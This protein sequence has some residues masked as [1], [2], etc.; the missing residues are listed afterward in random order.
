MDLHTRSITGIVVYAIMLPA[1]FGPFDFYSL[2]PELSLLFSS[3]MLFISAIRL[4]FWLNTDRIYKASGRL[5]RY[6]FYFLSTCHASVLATFFFY[7]IFD[8]SFYPVLY[9]SMLAIGGITSS[10]LIALSPRIKFAVMNV[11]VL[12]LPSIIGGLLIDDKLPFAIMMFVYTVFI[13]LLGIRSHKEYVRSFDIETQL[14]EQKQALEHINKTDA[15]TNVYNRGFFNIE[16]ESQWQSAARHN[17][18]M[19]LMFIDIDHFKKFND[20]H[21]HLVGD[22]C[23][24]Q[25]AQ[26][27]KT[28]ITRETD[29][30]A[31]YGGEEFVVLLSGCNLNDAE[32]LAEGLCRLID[33]ATIN[34][35]DKSL[36]VTASIGVASITPHYKIDS[37]QLIDNAD[38]ALY[39][40]KNAGRNCV[41]A[42]K[43][44]LKSK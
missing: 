17:I 5:W 16:Y 28:H 25:I 19:S 32:R 18:E 2:Q 31:R 34:I 43:K 27:V 10:A 3:A 6:T 41:F 9:V 24:I 20:V 39:K 42:Y 12:M 13:S 8:A 33:D 38:K 40:A 35:D 15:L 29:L 1:V 4:A 23:I 26:L 14:Q 22:Q 44:H 21:G 37:N 36:E 11:A 30:V 7:A